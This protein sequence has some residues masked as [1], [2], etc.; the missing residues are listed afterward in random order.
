[1]LIKNLLEDLGGDNI[2]RENPIPVQNVRRTS[3]RYLQTP[4]ISLVVASKL[5]H[6]RLMSLF[7][8]R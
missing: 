1:M 4:A 7:C 5:T 8:E 3:E 6:H 2:N